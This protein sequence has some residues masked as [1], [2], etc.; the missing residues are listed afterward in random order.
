[1]RN[2]IFVLLYCVSVIAADLKISQL[3]LGSGSAVG[4][5]DSFPYVQ[6]SNSITK[7]LTIYDIVN[8]PL[9]VNTYAPKANPTFTGV[10]TAPSFVGPLTGNASTATALAENPTD[11]SSGQFANAIAANGNLTCAT[12]NVSSDITGAVPIANGGTGQTTRQAAINALTLPISNNTVLR[13]NGTNASFSSVVLNTDV[14]GTLPIENGGTGQTSFSSGYIKSNGSA[15]SSSSTVASSDISGVIAIAN[16]GTNS[17]ATP[18]SG[19]VGYGTGSALAYT[20]AGTSGQ[21]LKSAGTSA[22]S[23][24]SIVS[25]DITGVFPI[26][27]GGTNNGSLAVTAGGV[28]Y[29]DG[30]KLV[31]VGAG[32]S[33]Q[34]L[35]SNGAS[36]PSWATGGGTYPTSGDVVTY[37][38]ILTC[39]ASSSITTNNGLVSSIGNRGATGCTVTIN[40]GLFAAAPA[41]SVTRAGAQALTG[42]TAT[43]ATSIDI[44]ATNSGNTFIDFVGGV[45]CSGIKP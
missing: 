36:A 6:A 15:L 32:T 11:C 25:S 4:V 28:I 16:G 29:T 5:N 45:V 21:F 26:S 9:F 17:T 39:S 34:F 8:V 12:I 38:A 23:F 13:S 40:S 35:K 2:F 18:T 19:G 37:S 30:T 33:G 3:P 42:Y 24:A 20:S 14:S 1:M 31:N 22:P 10:V 7:R 44:Y 27:N 43:S 41:C